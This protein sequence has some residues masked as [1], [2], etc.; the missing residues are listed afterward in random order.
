[1]SV[2]SRKMA[3]RKTTNG[4]RTECDFASMNDGVR[5]SGF[6][7]GVSMDGDGKAHDTAGFSV[8]VVAAPNSKELPAV[9]L[10]EAGKVLAGEG[11]HRAISNI[12]SLG[13]CSGGST[14]TSKQASM[15]SWTFAINSSM[16][17]PCVA[18]PGIAGT[19]AQ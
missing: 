11:L 14:S 4:M 7:G 5:E 16:V 13:V 15:A 8:D 6:Q 1:M 19:S 10:D 2:D 17:S 18:Q 12:W 3:N 9:T